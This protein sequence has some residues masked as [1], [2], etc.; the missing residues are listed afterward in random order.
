MGVPMQNLSQFRFGL[1]SMLFAVKLWAIALAITTQSFVQSVFCGTIAFGVLT[2]LL[3]YW[4]I[5][6]EP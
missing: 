2:S 5:P 1:R 6:R 3:V 4:A